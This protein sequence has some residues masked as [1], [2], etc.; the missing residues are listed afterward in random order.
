MDVISQALGT[1]VPLSISVLSD[2]GKGTLRKA[3]CNTSGALDASQ[4][5][6]LWEKLI[7][8]VQSPQVTYKH[9]TSASN[10]LCVFLNGGAESSNP[11]IRTFIFSDQT[12]FEAF[13][14]AHRT[15]NDGKTKPAFQIMETLCDMIQRMPHGETATDILTKAVHPL[16]RIVLL[17]S[18]RSELKKACLM[19]TYLLRRTPILD[20][21]ASL[22]GRCTEE[23]HS[24][25]MQRLSEHNLSLSDVSN[26][27]NDSITALL[28]ALILAMIDLDTRTSALKL[29]SALRSTFETAQNPSLQ[30]LAEISVK[31]FL[32]RNHAT[33]GD[34]AE[35][36]LPIIIGNK[37]RFLNFIKPYAFSCYE[38]ESKMVLFLSLLKV[39]RLKNMLAGTGTYIVFIPQL[40]DECM[41]TLIQCIDVLEIF[42]SA[43]ST[44]SSDTYCERD[45]YYWFKGT[46]AVAS[47]E[48]RILAYGLLTSSPAANG[49]FPAG[50]LKCIY[51]GL[52][53]LHDDA[54]AH[55]RSEILSITRRLLK[56]LQ[57]SSSSLR[58]TMISPARSEETV[59]I[60]AQ[61]RSFSTRFYNFL[62]HE[63]RS[64]ISYQ[65]HI[66][67]LQSLRYFI[68]LTVEP[69]IFEEDAELVTSLGCLVLDP[70]DDVRSTAASLLQYLAVKRP[71]LVARTINHRFVYDAELLAIRTVRADHADGMGRLWAL[72]DLSCNEKSACIQDRHNTADGTELSRLISQ[73]EQLTSDSKNVR[74]GSEVA[75]HG[76]LLAINYRLRDLKSQGRHHPM[77]DARSILNLC[78]QVWNQVRAYLCVD[79]PE[80]ELEDEDGKGGPKDILAYSWRALRDSS[81]VLQSLILA[82]QP[83]LALYS[84]LGDICMDQL[85]SLRHRGAFSTVAQTF[86]LCCEKVHAAPEVAMRG[87]GQRWFAIALN[88]IDQQSNRL[89]RRSAGLP[90]MI[91]GLLSPIDHSFF[92]SAISDLVDIAQRPCAASLD[93]LGEARLPQ[94][95]A[96]NCLKEIMTNSRFSAVVIQFLAR[97][98]EL[99][100][101]CLSSKV[102]AIRN[103]GLMLLRACINRLDLT[104]TSEAIPSSAQRLDKDSHETPLTI[105]LRLLQSAEHFGDISTRPDTATERVFAALDLLGHTHPGAANEEEVAK[106]ITRELSHSNWAVRDHAAFLLAT[107]LSSTDPLSAITK[108]TEEVETS[109]W[110]SQN[111]AH[112]ALLCCRYIMTAAKGPTSE[113]ELSSIVEVLI[114]SFAKWPATWNPDSLYVG[115]ALLDL[116]NDAAASV[117]VNGWDCR[118]VVDRSLLQPALPTQRSNSRHGAYFVQR[119]LVHK[120]YC[121]L[122]RTISSTTQAREESSLI[123][124]LVVQSDALSFLLETLREKHCHRPRPS[125]VVFLIR[126]IHDSCDDLLP[127]PDVLV[128][129][130][131]CLTECLKHVEDVPTEML[132]TLSGKIELSQLLSSRE[133]RNAT[134]K[135]E[136]HVLGVDLSVHELDIR[137][138]QRTIRWLRALEYASMDSMDFPT[139]LSAATALSTFSEYLKVSEASGKMYKIRLRLLLI[140]Y[141]LLNDDDDDVRFEAVQAARKLGLHEA[142]RWGNLGLCALAARQILLE[143]LCQQYGKTRDL[144][145]SAIIRL[146]QIGLN[147]NDAFYHRVLT[148]LSERSVASQLQ[149]ICRGKNDLFA[150]ERQNLYIDDI[151]EIKSWTDILHRT[152]LHLLTSEQSRAAVE[153]TL[154][155]LDQ[156]LH[157]LQVDWEV[158]SSLQS[159]D[160]GRE[161]DHHILCRGSGSN[162]AII[163]PLGPSYDHEILVVLLPV[164]SLAG[165]LLRNGHTIVCEKLQQIKSLCLGSQANEILACA[166]NHALAEKMN[167]NSE[168][169]T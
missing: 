67:S 93:A 159:V 127:Q 18:P 156:V 49:I 91:T 4:V 85:T 44:T 107:R 56:T 74:P 54:D 122:S 105:A 53:Y 51:S 29:Y 68:D 143:T 70:F 60:P 16:I 81:L 87:L 48:V 30:N 39:G 3:F 101:T 31:V 73:L 12:W 116:L 55:E 112:G 137:T 128:Q 46:L 8:T 130:F 80:M 77:F 43:L 140:L 98:L 22:A 40:E 14:C 66:L 109:G 141:D 117:F 59:N 20:H 58:K 97:I 155:G 119:A 72:W 106:A 113:S 41:L 19:L 79:S 118:I 167:E 15:F 33:L 158:K 99:A 75:I 5:L 10:A 115:A 168:S 36:V 142:Q 47:S 37:E 64:G 111:Q 152:S 28:L 89:T 90:A 121:H 149:L 76:S 45:E 69:D 94:V 42:N 71:S 35:N 38:G 139:R 151:C 120:T 88:E 95:H 123:S 110:K 108:L 65:R 2:L 133:L 11:Q 82:A 162:L 23:Y 17:S 157:V 9:I 24:A 126:L 166:V 13:Q 124:E 96:L 163:H 1:D 61:Y 125:L 25:W 21:I 62:K 148:I 50:A 27:G 153:W 169:G 102:W 103:C 144:V 6:A 131:I 26:V 83:N 78:L 104:P 161:E 145:E 147:E 165:V 57:T 52:K 134:L 32:E 138:E 135:L 150:E 132:R 114:D 86:N 63:L 7:S 154:A 146:L 100:A 160:E 164:V 84:S 129:A 92:S 34:F 136:A